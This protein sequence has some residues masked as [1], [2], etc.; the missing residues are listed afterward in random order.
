MQPIHSFEL[1]TSIDVANHIGVQPETVRRW[2]RAGLIPGRRLSHKVLRFCLADVV[3]ALEAHQKPTGL[4]V[5][6]AS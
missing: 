4:E 3:A 6:H 1:S 5:D 2:Y